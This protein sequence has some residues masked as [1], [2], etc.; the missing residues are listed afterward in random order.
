VVTVAYRISIRTTVT[1]TAEQMRENVAAI[2]E[3]LAEIEQNTTAFLGF[4][5]SADRRAGTAFFNLYVD[6]DDPDRATAAAN[7]WTVTA[8][9]AAGDSARGWAMY[10]HP[11]ER[12]RVP[13]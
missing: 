1:G 10:P 5:V 13:A 3:Y 7:S 8:I 9:T 2:A 4:T 11:A 6:E 12:E